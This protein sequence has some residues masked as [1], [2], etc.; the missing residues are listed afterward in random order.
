MLARITS[1]FEAIFSEEYIPPPQ[2]ELDSL[3][4]QLSK[5]SYPDDRIPLCF[6]C[7]I[8]YELMENPFFINKLQTHTFDEVCL[9]E[10]LQTDTFDEAW[11]KETPRY[12]P[13]NLEITSIKKNI[14]RKKQIKDFVSSLVRIEVLK[15]LV[16][17]QQ[18]LLSKEDDEINLIKLIKKKMYLATELHFFINFI[19]QIVNIDKDRKL[20]E[21]MGEINLITAEKTILLQS[22]NEE[23][24]DYQKLT[25][26]FM[27]IHKYKMI[28]DDLEFRKKKYLRYLKK[29]LEEEKILN[30]EIDLLIK[31]EEKSLNKEIVRTNIKLSEKLQL[32]IALIEIFNSDQSE[33][34]LK[35]IFKIFAY[36][37]N[38]LITLQADFKEFQRDYPDLFYKPEYEFKLFPPQRMIMH[39]SPNTDATVS[40]RFSYTNE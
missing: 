8:S 36:E 18:V 27:K 30:Y 5:I 16:S 39:L 17:K 9:K 3:V 20:E 1:L 2:Y 38:L 24:K 14:E 33:Y 37:I 7:P 21:K 13:F 40:K 28:L 6:L 23:L 12:D 35:N 34:K 11:I 19:N 29:D 15:E 26:T 31:G 4:D 32:C 10:A 25:A 22:L